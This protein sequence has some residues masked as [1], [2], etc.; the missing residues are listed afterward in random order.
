VL[1]A[2]LANQSYSIHCMVYF[3]LNGKATFLGSVNYYW[4]VVCKQI[5]N[6]YIVTFWNCLLDDSKLTRSELVLFSAI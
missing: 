2:V 3:V 6:A 1:T 4:N 5:I